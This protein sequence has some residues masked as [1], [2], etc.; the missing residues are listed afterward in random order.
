[1]KRSIIACL[2][3]LLLIFQCVGAYAPDVLLER[4]TVPEEG[5]TS[6]TTLDGDDNDITTPPHTDDQTSVNTTESIGGGAG[7]TSAE[8]VADPV[9]E[10]ITPESTANITEEVPAAENATPVVTVTPEVLEEASNSTLIEDSN[11]TVL[12]EN[13]TLHRLTFVVN[14][15]SIPKALDTVAAAA[16]LNVTLLNET[17]ALLYDFSNE[18]LLFLASLDNTTVESVNATLN[19]NATVITF[20]LSDG[21]AAGIPVDENMTRYWL[22]GGEEN[23]NNLILA[24]DEVGYGTSHNLTA[25][26]PPADR[27]EISF[28]TKGNSEVKLMN[29]VADDPF[30][31]AEI[32][33]T[34]YLATSYKD[35]PFDLGNSDVIILYHLTP[36]ALNALKDTVMQ[37]REKGAEVI[38]CGALEQSYH[39]HTVDPADD[40]FSTIQ[41]YITYI[42]EKNGN[43]LA[44]FIGV[45]YCNL[46]MSVEPPEE[47]PIYGIYHPDAPGIFFDSASY[48][49][50][51][52]TTDTYDAAAPTVG[53]MFS[54]FKY[55][56]RDR[57]LFDGVIRSFEDKGANVIVA[58][59]SRK[60]PMGVGYF[61]KDDEALI[62]TAVRVSTGGHRLNSKDPE[63]G[64]EDLQKL[65]VPTFNAFGLFYT[66]ETTWRNSPHGVDLR[67]RY[68]LSYAE[69][70]GLI[71]PIVIAAKE[72]N[73]DTGTLCNKPI[74]DQVAWLTERVLGWA[75]L[76]R[77]SNGE[78]KIVIPYYAAAGG[79]V[80]V[81][82]DI[83]YY[84]DAPASLSALLGAMQERGY[85]LGSEP[86]PDAD[87]L[88]T[89]MKTRGH[90]IA[91]WA[92]EILEQRVQQG[93]CILI[94]E[95]QYL[96]WFHTLPQEKQDEMIAVWGP[97]PGEI[98]VH[99]GSL[100]IPTITYGNVVLAPHPLWGWNQDDGT[101]Y[102]DGSVPPT[103]QCLAF[104]RY[105]DQVH[106]ADAI[107]SVFSNMV[108]MP[109]KEAGLAADDWGA[110]MNG[111]MPHIHIVPMDAPGTSSSRRAN[112]AVV[113][114]MTPVI[115][116]SGLYGSF[117]D[118]EDSIANYGSVADDAVKAQYKEEILAAVQE[119]RLDRALDVD[120]TT[121][122]DDPDA[123][124]AFLPDLSRYLRE[125]KTTLMPY[126][127]H[128]LSEVPEG[129][130]L[131]A[132]IEAMLGQEYKE[133]V[134]TVDQAKGASTVLLSAVVLN[135]TSPASAQLEVL[136]TTS[137]AI[138]SDLDLALGYLERINA[139]S[140]EIPRIL[141]A[142]EAKYI[143]PGPNG[144]PIRNPDALPTGRN[145]HTFDDRTVP[146]RAAWEV[147]KEMGDD[148]LQIQLEA[149]GEYPDKVAFLLWSCE[150]SRTQGIMESEIFAMLGVQPVWDTRNRVKDVELIPS[151]ELGRPRIDVLVT[152]SG[153]YRDLYGSKLELIEK[154]V[155]LAAEADDGATPNY[156]KVHAEAIYQSLRE[157]GY[158]E[159]E[160]RQLSRARIF[161]PPPDS[162]G[163]G[164]ERA[165]GASD[166][167]EDRQKIADL[168][169]NRMGYIYGTEIWGEQYTDVFKENLGDVD[170]GVFSRSSNLYGAL[171]HSQVAA[172]FGGLSLAI[173][174]VSGNAPEMYINNL[175][176]PDGEVVET[177]EKFVS[178][179]LYSRYLNPAWIKGMMEHGSDGARYM[180]GFVENMWVWDV[181]MPDLITGEMWDSVYEAYV[182]DCHDLG[183][184]EYMD[185]NNPHAFQS[186]AAR[187]LDAARTGNWNPSEAVKQNLAKEYQKSVDA[188]GVTCC[189][190]TCGNLV[191]GEYIDGVASSVPQQRSSS[192]SGGGGDW[193]P[194]PQQKT[195]GDVVAEKEENTG[196]DNAATNT[197][198][199]SAGFG[200]SGQSPAEQGAQSSDS[201]ETVSGKVMKEQTKESSLASMTGTPLL[202]F[203]LVLAIL[204]A[205]AAGFWYRRR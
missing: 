78:K 140:V 67:Q 66:N 58:T 187:M 104:Y 105:M 123:F 87:E 96:E 25:P 17:S 186:M 47:R 6:N 121:L 146:T 76:H 4:G 72:L 37:A 164:I 97:P 198:A 148:L 157:A 116:P 93:D 194:A 36:T 28:V 201:G 109:G 153:P 204:G 100:V 61:F 150:T 122:Q 57:A 10:N 177:L 22:Y 107:F 18:S 145:L 83:D 130:S 111:D 39:L 127:A 65:N 155:R 80:N 32:N 108:L 141:D 9:A 182:E 156:V 191:L 70:D 138:T 115:V 137:S 20:G 44:R 193:D 85:D 114:F 56:D 152:T 188:H 7:N 24:L 117:A 202:A 175:R 103:H 142:L 38:A 189:H 199:A 13:K 95:S 68:Q 21:P 143:P 170:C 91:T 144:D 180:D 31:S 119:Q 118:L 30:I 183:V 133:H 86:L 3:V 106:E 176:D 46:S 84:L 81:G 34:A 43:N 158:T 165:I 196:K 29:T 185:S 2:L 129:E 167:W 205:V 102:H 27:P 52:T 50:W 173:E 92:P 135:G 12:E 154:A 54:S 200:T 42:S 89:L 161:C 64:I 184:T 69:Q 1:M 174:H 11:T 62:E 45:T 33:A 172:Y 79:K 40:E 159:D 90:N 75:R 124:E 94:P 166:T 15:T 49:D 63:R 125:M 197:T 136:G 110:I 71:E 77:A 74:D 139:C 163:T 131:V 48:L 26:V 126:G 55:L 88:A 73:S 149:D 120:L 181:S 53:I 168:F 128:V 101:I 35:S 132:M 82:A 195:D 112:M 162:Y 59:Y 134:V 41:E 169:I 203:V 99:D 19:E 178:R 16:P 160:A 98:M 60:D 51:Y 179:D 151:S 171:D 23:L 190:H 192:S 5:E 8:D 147:G 14:E 113:D